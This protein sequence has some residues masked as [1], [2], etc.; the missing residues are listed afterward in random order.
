MEGGRA[1]RHSTLLASCPPPPEPCATPKRPSAISSGR[2]FGAT[3][4]C[5]PT[6]K[7]RSNIFTRTGLSPGAHPDN[8]LDLFPLSSNSR[9]DFTQLEVEAFRRIKAA[10]LHPARPQKISQKITARY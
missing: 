3:Q 2:N 9:Y 7:L 1:P 10:S 8:F 4:K 6:E 5:P